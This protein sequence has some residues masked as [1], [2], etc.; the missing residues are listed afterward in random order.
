MFDTD[1][2]HRRLKQIVA[3]VPNVIDMGK[4]AVT[5]QTLMQLPGPVEQL[6]K[7][8]ADIVSTPMVPGNAF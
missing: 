6:A 4:E 2:D 7:G 8:A 1:D 5:L 3:K